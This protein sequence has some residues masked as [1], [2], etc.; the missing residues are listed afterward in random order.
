MPPVPPDRVPVLEADRREVLRPGVE[1]DRRPAEA[2]A[3]AAERARIL[4]DPQA[5]RQFPDCP[6]VARVDQDRT[7]H[8]P[9][10]QHRPF[11]DADAR[12]LL[13]HLVQV[14]LGGVGAVGIA[15]GVLEGVDIHDHLGLAG[16]EGDQG[17]AFPKRPDIFGTRRLRPPRRARHRGGRGGPLSAGP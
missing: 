2:A 1:L 17:G 13:H 3:V 7:A 5:G 15:V 9:S 16:R 14:P 11:Q 8:G 4:D 6:G 12:D 10:P